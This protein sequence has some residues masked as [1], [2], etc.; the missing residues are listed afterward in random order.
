MERI[1]RIVLRILNTL[2]YFQ[3]HLKSMLRIILRVMKIP[4]F[5]LTLLGMI[6]GSSQSLESRV[7]L[8]SP[9]VWSNESDLK[10]FRII[11]FVL[12]LLSPL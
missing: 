1:S 11:R 10:T 9:I 12:D 8:R 2:G 3:V 7:E 4:D 6:L 5:H